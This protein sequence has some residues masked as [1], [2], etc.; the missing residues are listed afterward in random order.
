MLYITT[1]SQSG[2]GVNGTFLKPNGEVLVDGSYFKFEATGT[3]EGKKFTQRGPYKGV[4]KHPEHENWNRSF[5]PEFDSTG[6]ACVMQLEGPP[7]CCRLLKVNPTTGKA[8]DNMYL[9]FSG[10]VMEKEGG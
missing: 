3:H 9:N 10:N 8:M 2:R 4:S 5:H 7:S 1:E 6:D